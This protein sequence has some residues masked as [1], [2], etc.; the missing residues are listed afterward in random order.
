MMAASQIV[1]RNCSKEEKEE[2]GYIGVCW[3]KKTKTKKQ[4]AFQVKQVSTVKSS[5]S[6]IQSIFAMRGFCSTQDEGR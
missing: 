3:K 4:Q 2:P 1:L 5:F 6:L